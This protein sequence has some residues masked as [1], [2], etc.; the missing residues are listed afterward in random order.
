MLTLFHIWYF[1]ALEPGVCQ[2]F[3]SFRFPKTSVLN[4]PDLDLASFLQPEDPYVMCRFWCH[5]H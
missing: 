5:G 3:E 4:L 2:G 1:L